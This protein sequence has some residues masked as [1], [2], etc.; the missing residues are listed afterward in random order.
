MSG[1]LGP[2]PRVRRRERYAIEEA[3]GILCP[4]RLRRP[5]IAEVDAELE[6]ERRKLRSTVW[7]SGFAIVLSCL[8]MQALSWVLG[9]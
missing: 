2:A 1:Y 9:A 6:A 8:S 5:A 7:V 4:P 3:G